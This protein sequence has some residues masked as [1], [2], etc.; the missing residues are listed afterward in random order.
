M[1]L[2]HLTTCS[3]CGQQT[4]GVELSPG[5]ISS[6]CR[7]GEGCQAKTQ[8]VKGEK[9]TAATRRISKHRK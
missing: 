1:S 9:K 2:P 8:Q 3:R 4:F 6:I 5:S 7:P